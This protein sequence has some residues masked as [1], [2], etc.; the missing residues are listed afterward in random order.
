M[1]GKIIVPT[2]FH[3]RCCSS[4]TYIPECF[5]VLVA[6]NTMVIEGLVFTLQLVAQRNLR[7]VG[8]REESVSSGVSAVLAS[9]SSSSSYSRNSCCF[10]ATVFG[11]FIVKLACHY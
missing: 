4:C 10:I 1:P 5:A 7:S 9:S 3:S 8:H 6:D 11:K 2:G